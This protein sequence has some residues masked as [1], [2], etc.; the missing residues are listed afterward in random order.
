M[1][2]EMEFRDR[3][4]KKGIVVANVSLLG[5]Y[6]LGNGYFFGRRVGRFWFSH[7]MK[8]GIGKLF[9]SLLFLLLPLFGSRR[10]SIVA[11]NREDVALL[12]A[13]NCHIKT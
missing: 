13:S 1:L 10:A 8:S 11:R 6:T 2:L 7:T 4:D 9:S 3:R 12:L 5:V